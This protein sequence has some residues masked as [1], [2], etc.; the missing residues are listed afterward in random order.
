MKKIALCALILAQV[1]GC[2]VG[3]QPYPDGDRLFQ[4]S[5]TLWEIRIDRGGEKLFAGLLALEMKGGS[6]D[7]VLLDGTGIKLLE[8]RVLASGEVVNISTLPAIRNKRLA[9]LLGKGLHRLFFSFGE[10]EAEACR[11][12]GLLEYCFG[13]ESDGHLVKLRRLGPFVLWSVDYFVNNYDSSLGVNT[14]RLNS[15]WFAPTLSLK[16]NVAV[17]EN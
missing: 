12:H 9:P 1:Y 5:Q 7:A 11:R 17:S 8:E 13:V 2:A 10:E 4:D 3:L 6:L 14:A 15:G 16:R